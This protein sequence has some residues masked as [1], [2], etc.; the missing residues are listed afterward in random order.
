MQELQG[1]NNTV[2]RSEMKANTDTR[3]MIESFITS[4][5]DLEVKKKEIADDIKALKDDYKEEGIPVG[6]VVAAF[7]RAK[8]NKKKSE[9]ELN[10]EEVIQEWINE[11]QI[12]D[13]AIMKVID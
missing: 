9:S 4:L 11:S 5:A 12:V 3:I 6:I 1:T 13:E 8:K 10:E 7:N 2:E